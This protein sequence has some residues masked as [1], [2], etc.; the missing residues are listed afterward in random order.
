MFQATTII[1]YFLFAPFVIQAFRYKLKTFRCQHSIVNKATHRDS[2]GN[3]DDRQKSKKQSTFN[4]TPVKKGFGA[5]TNN[6][7]KEKTNKTAKQSLE[8]DIQC[9]IGKVPGLQ[10]YMD[11]KDDVNTWKVS[12]PSSS[13]SSIPQDITDKMGKLDILTQQGFSTSKA[14]EIL[15]QITWDASASFRHQRHQ[16]MVVSESAERFMLQV[17]SWCLLNAASGTN[18]ILDCGTGDGIL[19]RFL[20]K[21]A[22]EIQKQSSLSPSFQLLG[23]DLS[24]NMINIAKEMYP[25]HLFKHIG[26]LDY[27]PNTM[28][29]RFDPDVVVFNECLHYF[30]NTLEALRQADSLLTSNSENSSLTSL[31][32]VRIVASHPK[33]FNNVILQRSV[34]HHLVPSILPSKEEVQIFAEK[35][36]YDSLVLPD[37]KAN[38]YLFVLEKKV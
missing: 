21:A 3:F 6:K 27:R 7:D 35:Y 30:D 19:V 12:H 10:E 37:T 34:N 26:F 31:R 22:L 15:N 5:I 14:S 8:D 16:D 23:I 25:D 18:Q 29:P 1:F 33:G 17:A 38:S 36:Q 13:S 9:S 4:V 20:R 2:N 11:L 32:R 24:A 28:V